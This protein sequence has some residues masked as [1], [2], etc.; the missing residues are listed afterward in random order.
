[1]TGHSRRDF[2]RYGLGAAAA[3]S[4]PL[5]TLSLLQALGISSAQAAG[6]DY[7]A[8]VCIFL[9]GGNDGYNVL[10]PLDPIEYQKYATARGNLALSPADLLPTTPLNTGGAV[11]GINRNMLKVHEMFQNGTAAFVVNAGTLLAPTTKADY[12]AQRELPPRL[13]SH[14]DQSDEWMSH[15]PDAPQRR[16]WAGKLA[17]VLS[18]FNGSAKLSFN[19][20]IA[21]NNLFQTG[22]TTVPYSISS[23]G[24]SRLNAFPQNQ[25]ALRGAF[26]AIRAQAGGGH[27]MAQHHAAVTDRAIDLGAEVDAALSGVT[28]ATAFPDTSLGSQLKMAARMIGARATLGMKRQVFFVAQGGYDTHDTQLVSHPLLL[29]ALSDAVGAFHAATTE[30]G[31]ADSVASFTMSDF[32]RTLTS[33]G[34]GSDHAWG[35]IHLLAGGAVAGRSLYGAYPDVT[36]DGPEDAGRGRIIPTTS[37]EQYGATLGRWMGASESDLDTVFPHLQRFATR[38]LGFMA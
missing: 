6:D 4:S 21:G 27:L 10:A 34:D 18:S 12:K 38:D 11:Y 25:Q 26:D 8:L 20:S 30:L 28:L 37:V 36:I 32:G 19:V 33:N 2:L 3:A 24:V 35:N 9:Y 31:I 22:D 7:R 29:T 14:N 15:Q 17:E 13:F 16:G 1:M 5:S 23:G